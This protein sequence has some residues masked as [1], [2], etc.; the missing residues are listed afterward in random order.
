MDESRSEIVYRQTERRLQALAGGNDA[1]IRAKL[2]NLRQAVGR[3]PGD[4]PRVWGILFSDLPEAILG[5]RGEPSREEWAI[6]TALTL[7]ALHQQGEDLKQ[8]NMNRKKVSLGTAASRLAVE[9]ARKDDGTIDDCRQRVSRR[10]HQVVLADDMPTMVY[11]LRG[12]IQLLR[13]SG[14]GLDYPMLARDLYLY[15]FP[16]KAS[17]VRLQWGQDF[18]RKDTNEEERKEES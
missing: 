6:Y 10:F 8:N 16:D 14:V 15:Q 12:F 3:R 13:S 17:D 9:Y 5:Q 4:D 18:Y 2:A 7:Y 11:Y 1:E